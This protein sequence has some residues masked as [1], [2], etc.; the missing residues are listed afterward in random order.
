MALTSGVLREISYS[1][2]S[3][4]GVKPEKTGAK[5]LRRVTA[6]INL[7]RETFE[8]AEITSTAQTSDMRSGTDS[9]KGSL[10]GEVSPGSYSDFFASLLRGT[11]KNGVTTG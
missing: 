9:V 11:W 4:F 2:E 8:S 5:R 3:A 6:E 7:E 1:K 10:N